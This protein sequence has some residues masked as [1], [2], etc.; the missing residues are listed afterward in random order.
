MSHK[1]KRFII[2]VKL[3]EHYFEFFELF[4]QLQNNYIWTGP[5]LTKELIEAD[6][7]LLYYN[8]NYVH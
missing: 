1:L 3:S 2:F 4:S 8:I 5:Q 7:V 6:Q